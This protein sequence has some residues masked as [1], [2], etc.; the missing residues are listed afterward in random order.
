MDEAV[1]PEESSEFRDRTATVLY[2]DFDLFMW[3]RTDPAHIITIVTDPWQHLVIHAGQRLLVWFH[4][5]SGKHIPINPPTFRHAVTSADHA[6]QYPDPEDFPNV[7]PIGHV[8]SSFPIPSGSSFSTTPLHT[9]LSS[10]PTH[11]PDPPH[12]GNLIPGDVTGWVFNLAG[13][14][15]DTYIPEGTVIP[16]WFHNGQWWTYWLGTFDESSSS[17][18]S[19]VSTESSTSSLSTVSDSSISSHSVTSTSSIICEQVLPH[20][21]INWPTL[22]G[23]DATKKQALIH[24]A[25]CW[26]WQT[27]KV[28]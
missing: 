5:Q 26:E 1:G 12:G 10:L 21:G 20:S 25:G 22:P 16:T 13:A 27:I 14:G 19:S 18:T 2:W 9:V 11:L 15:D 3:R 17:S 4:R 6:N 24:D 7:Y 23:Y 28:C 8:K